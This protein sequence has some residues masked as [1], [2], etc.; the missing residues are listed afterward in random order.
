MIIQKPASL[1]VWQ[2]TCAKS[3]YKAR[4]TN[5]G[6]DLRNATQLNET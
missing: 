2:S 6:E 1:E 4:A 5:V 3:Y